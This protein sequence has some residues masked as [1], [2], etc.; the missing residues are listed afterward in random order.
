MSRLVYRLMRGSWGLACTSSRKWEVK[1]WEKS[2]LECFMCVAR[3]ECS[4]EV[5]A[6]PRIQS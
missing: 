2:W 4:L 1:S 3:Y 6:L 5:I